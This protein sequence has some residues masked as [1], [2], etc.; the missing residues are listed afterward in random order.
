MRLFVRINPNRP[1]TNTAMKDF[2]KYYIDLSKCTEEQ[3]KSFPQILVK[4]RQ[5]YTPGFNDN[6]SDSDIVH[7]HNTW[8]TWALSV[9]IPDDKTELTYPEFIKLF[10]KPKTVSQSL[11]EYFKITTKEQVIKD[12][13]SV[14]EFDNVNSPI[15]SELFEGGDGEKLYRP[16]TEFPPITEGEQHSKMVLV[17]DED[18]D[19]CDL[20]F[21][22]FDTQKW[23]VLGG[24]QMNLICW[25]HIEKPKYEDVQEYPTIL[26]D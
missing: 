17:F 1:K 26:T 9:G 3:R 7:F 8:K 2:S 10:E 6:L 22:N 14:S 25:R 4:N 24:F 15:V 18:L 23:D 21:Y 11:K 19:D 12:W 16:M 13:E 20:G 5:K